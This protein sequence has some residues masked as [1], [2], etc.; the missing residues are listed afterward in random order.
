MAERN[1]NSRIIQ[2]HDTETNWLKATNFIPKLGELIIYDI[3]ATHDYA[4]IKIGDGT[5]VVSS[6]PFYGTVSIKAWTTSDIT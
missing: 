3:D 2:K 6:L 4:R 1:I 5:T